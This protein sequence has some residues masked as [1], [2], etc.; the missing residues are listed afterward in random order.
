MTK[1][2]CNTPYIPDRLAPCNFPPYIEAVKHV[3]YKKT[4]IGKSDCFLEVLKIER[5]TPWQ[6]FIGAYW[7]IYA[8]ITF[9][10]GDAVRL[11]KI[12]PYIIELEGGE[13]FNFKAKCNEG[14]YIVKTGEGFLIWEAENEANGFVI[15][16]LAP[17]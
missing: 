7:R 1:L 9:F 15:E 13:N 6:S 17:K 3:K 11:F 4:R 2:N 8:N 10:D 14:D 5:G 12:P 16:N